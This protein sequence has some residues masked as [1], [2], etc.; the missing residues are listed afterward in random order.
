MKS[1]LFKFRNY[2]FFK[3][4]TTAIVLLLLAVTSCSK[5]S[6][7]KQDPVFQLPPETQIG[8]N[9][10]GVTIN[11]KVYVPRD[12]TGVNVGGTTP[13]GMRLFGSGTTP[14]EYMELVVVDGAS[15]VGFKITIHTQNLISLGIGQYILKQSNFQSQAD[16]V[17]FNHIFFKIWDSTIG[18][19][20]Y[21]GSV[22]GQGNI[23]ITRLDNGILSGKFAGKFVRYDNSNKFIQILDGRF[24]IGPDLNSKIFP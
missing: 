19:Y 22:E 24:D 2:K 11:G 20:A 10:F 12:P 8:A 21:Y 9:T 4:S 7:V 23:D 15:A 16:S 6:S 1:K 14:S 17:P 13:R 18:N 5:D 3:M